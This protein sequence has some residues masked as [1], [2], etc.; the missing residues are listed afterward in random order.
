MSGTAEGIRVV[1]ISQLDVAPKPYR[2]NKK[3]RLLVGDPNWIS[4]SQRRVVKRGRRCAVAESGFMVI[5]DITGYT[6]YLNDSELEHARQSLAAILEVIVSSTEAPLVVSGVVGDAVL[7]YGVD[8]EILNT[9]TM[10]DELENIYLAYRRA[11]EQM[12]LNTTCSCTACANLGTLDLKFITHHG[13]F[14]IQHVAG[15]D[16]IIGPDVNKLFRL[17]KNDI[18]EELGLTA[19]LAFTTDALKELGMEEFSSKLHDVDQAV[20]DFGVVRLGVLDM[21]PVWEQRRYESPVTMADGETMLTF[22]RD[23]DA[24]LGVLWDHLT[25]PSKRSRL[26][27]SEPGGV[28]QGED[29]KMG[30]GGT[31]ICAHGKYRIPHRIVEWIPLVQYTFESEN[32]H[33]RHLW[34]M[35]LTDLGERTRLDVSVGNLEPMAPMKALMK[36][37]YKRYLRRETTKGLD[38]F[39][40]AVEAAGAA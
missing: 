1:I 35:R 8:G 7:S 10:V 38:E 26:F 34:Q 14:S 39:V 23:I 5:A 21:H 22:T 36:P 11:L 6:A 31:Y 3:S 27:Q 37:A 13:E 16:E 29:G 9:Q 19:Y 17:A 32:P 40:A 24:P 30:V 2:I 25:D 33:F 4:P 12:V 20:D 15:T 28:A 18:K